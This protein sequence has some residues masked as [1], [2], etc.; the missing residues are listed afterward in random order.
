MMEAAAMSVSEKPDEEPQVGKVTHSREKS[1][2]EFPYADIGVAEQLVTT[3]LNQGGGKATP[4]QLAAWMDISANGGTFRTRVSAARIFGFIETSRGSIEITDLGRDV[5]EGFSA[6]SA[7]VEAFLNVALF[8]ALLEQN[9]GRILP[10]PSALENQIV[11]CGVPF[12]QKERARQV[13][14]KS[15]KIAGF[16]DVSSGRFVK[17]A[18]HESIRR[19]D[20]PV[21]NEQDEDHG[22]KNRVEDTTFHPFIKGLLDEL[23]GKEEFSNWRIEDQAEWLQTAAGIFKLMSKQ[24]GR[25]KVTV[26]TSKMTNPDQQCRPGSEF[27]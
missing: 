18:T 19:N 5:V 24:Q 6:A 23:P 7:R 2:I 1:K 12:K 20:R 27:E 17:P 11:E 25:I 13:F 16:I 4:T 8:K 15:A 14:Q 21:D 22:N 3:L 9:N 10:P 26:E